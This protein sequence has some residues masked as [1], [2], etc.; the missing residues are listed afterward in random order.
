MI[1]SNAAKNPLPTKE[2]SL[3]IGLYKTKRIRFCACP[4]TVV[5]YSHHGSSYP[6]CVTDEKYAKEKKKTRPMS[7]GARLF[8]LRI[9]AS[10]FHPAAPESSFRSNKFIEDKSCSLYENRRHALHCVWKR[11]AI[12]R[13]SKRKRKRLN[14]RVSCNKWRQYFNFYSSTINYNTV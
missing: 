8:V 1:I 3:D 4:C 9:P 14:R 7:L 2:E 12:L 5:G 11:L 13:L 10:T 6:T